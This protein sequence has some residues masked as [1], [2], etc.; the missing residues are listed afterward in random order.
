MILGIVQARM[1]STRFPGKV[2]KKIN[3]KPLIEILFHRLSRSEKIDK[4]ILATSDS[5]E[6]DRL[7]ETVTKLGFDVFRGSEDDVLD[8]YYQAAKVYK[9]QVVVRITGDCPII[10]PEVVDK[11]IESYQKTNVIIPVTRNR[12]PIPMDLIRKCFHS[13]DWKLPIGTQKN[14]S[15]GNM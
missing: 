14:L 10:D 11:V 13:L 2:L 5:K 4:V 15:I 12:L 1:N 7:A 9:P 8:R 3:G 6:N